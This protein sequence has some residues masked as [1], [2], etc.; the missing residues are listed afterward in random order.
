MK[1]ETANKKTTNSAK[2]LSM[3]KGVT[4][5]LKYSRNETIVKISPIRKPDAK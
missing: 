5:D 4:C 2:I 1:R 3:D